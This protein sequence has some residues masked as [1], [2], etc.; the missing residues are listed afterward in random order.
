MASCYVYYRVLP[1]QASQ[2]LAAVTAVMD[3]LRDR[4]GIAGRLTRRRDDADM[5]MEIYDG[6]ADSV[7]FERELSAALSRHGMAHWLAGD[8]RKTEVFVPFAS[9]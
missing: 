4:T 6:I 9:S 2:V 7:A 8:A 5:W 3:E 1:T